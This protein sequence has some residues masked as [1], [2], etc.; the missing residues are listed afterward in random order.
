MDLEKLPLAERVR[1]CQSGATAYGNSRRRPIPA[2]PQE[3]GDTANDTHN[4]MTFAATISGVVTV[5]YMI[6]LSMR[7]I[8]S[9]IIN[10]KT[11]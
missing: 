10:H 5:W 11:G 1:R 9:C 6:R 8:A 2:I 4:D 3:P 7:P